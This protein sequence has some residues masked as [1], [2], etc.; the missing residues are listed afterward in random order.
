MEENNLKCVNS[1]PLTKGLITRRR[2]YLDEIREST[3]DFYVVCNRVLPLITS[4]EII[5]HRDHNLTSFK[6]K[7]KAVNSDH[8]PL[9]M[10]VELKSRPTVKEK[11]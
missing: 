6:T 1:L 10:E 7:S 11:V 9:L 8:A 4:M 3:I 2:R 5:D